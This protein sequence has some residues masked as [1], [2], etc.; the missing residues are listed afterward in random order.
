LGLSQADVADLLQ[1]P[2]RTYWSWESGRNAPN[3]ITQQVA[4][5]TLEGLRS[6]FVPTEAKRGRAVNTDA[7]VQRVAL[8]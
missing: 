4:V 1:T 8:A 3:K 5:A 6:D 7:I 2:F